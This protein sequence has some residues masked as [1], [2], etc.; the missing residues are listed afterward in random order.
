MSTTHSEPSPM[1]AQ[2]GPGPRSS[3]LDI[4]LP[5]LVGLAAV[6]FTAV[7]FI[8]DLI[9]V[10]QGGF[11]AFRLSLTYAGEAAIPIFVIGLYAVQRPRIGR[12]G[13]FGAVA[14]AYAYVFFTSTVVYALIA[15]TP[16][17]KALVRVFGAWMTIH[18]VIM[19]AG[20]LAFGLAVVR[21]GVLP[22]WTGV[23]LMA[24]VVLV[25]AAAGLPN[26]ARTVAAAV[27]GAAFIGMGAALLGARPKASAGR[28]WTMASMAAA[29]AA[30]VLLGRRIKRWRATGE[31]LSRS[32]PGDDEVG[33]PQVA[34]TRAVSISAPARVV[35][36]WLVQMGWHRAGWYS[37][38][39]FDNDKIPSADRIITELQSLQL[40]D[41]VPEGA[42]VGWTVAAVEPDHLLLLTTHGPMNGVDWLQ[43]RDSSWLFQ[44]DG[45]DAG[46]SRLIE[47]SRTA[48]TTNKDT[49]A[50][51]L[52]STPLGAA[53]LVGFFRRLDFVMAH[54]QMQGIKRRAEAQWSSTASS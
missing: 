49:T 53:A 18:G 4:G 16:D 7:Y 46:H 13:L 10:A 11:S 54:R 45:V 40:G 51:R 35:W 12:L 2:H 31:E 42:D 43:R 44:V 32:L 41:F 25:T 50:G 28:A 47:R 30:A 52:V 6:V 36:P 1:S 19:L 20:G 21:A 27:P 29:G 24:G 33:D 15:G 22:R 14:F 23:C 8:S 17:W 48:L 5:Q 37:Y 3:R 26:I 34:S 39:V 9:E 38:D